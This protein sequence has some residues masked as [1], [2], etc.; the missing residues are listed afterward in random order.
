MKSLDRNYESIVSAFVVAVFAAI[1][2]VV[3]ATND[4]PEFNEQYVQLAIA[5]LLI[6]TPWVFAARLLWRAWWAQHAARLSVMDGPARLLTVAISALPDERREW[7]AAM[8]AELEQVQDS[9]SRWR[10]AIGCARTAVFPPLTGR[11]RVLGVA[12]LAAISAAAVGPVVGYTLPA[13]RV[14]AVTFVALFG[15]L[16]TLA[17]A[18][19]RSVRQTMS[20]PTISAGGLLAVSACI[21]STAYFLIK[22]PEAQKH[23]PPAAAAIIATLLVGYLW[24]ALA[25]PRELTTHSHALGLGIAAAVVLGAGFVWVARLTVHTYGGPIIWTLFAPIPILFCASAMAAAID[26]SFRSGV[27]AAVWA[28]LFG[29]LMVVALTMPEA[30]HRFELDGRTL[31]DGESGYP[32]GVNLSGILWNLIQIPLVGLPFGVIGAAVGRRLRGAATSVLA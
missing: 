8:V 26:R 18:R 16:V 2:F 32:I 14:F 13:M 5:W 6:T 31:G 30:M 29:T 22:Y 10:F 4:P 1:A 21:A 23:L 25:P 27:Q 20:C 15:V 12:I 3:V 11:R 7:G 24:L 17:A 28:T 9:S 19:S